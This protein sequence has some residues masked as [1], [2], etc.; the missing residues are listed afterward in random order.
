MSQEGTWLSHLKQTQVSDR[1]REQALLQWK[2]MSD[3]F[4]AKMR[5]ARSSR[6]MSMRD[7]AAAIGSSAQAISKYETGKMLPQSKRLV[8]LAQL[9]DVS[10]DWLMCPCPIRLGCSGAPCVHGEAGAEINNK[11][12]G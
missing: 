4:G 12:A 10:I 11:C 5:V 2:S 3:L 8:A 9:Y 1:A 7:V 6:A